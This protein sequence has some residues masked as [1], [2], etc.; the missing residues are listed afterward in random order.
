VD[1][2]AVELVEERDAATEQDRHQVDPQLVEQTQ[3]QAPHGVEW[4]RRATYPSSDIDIS[5]TTFVPAPLIAP[6]PP[7]TGQV[8][9]AV[10]SRPVPGPGWLHPLPCPAVA[11]DTGLRRAGQTSAGGPAMRDGSDARTVAGV[12]TPAR[13]LVRHLAVALAITAAA[14]ACSDPSDGGEATTSPPVPETSAPTSTPPSS[15]PATLDPR[16]PRLPVGSPTDVTTGLAAP[17]SVAFVG[18]APLVSERDSGRILE[19][20]PDGSTRQVGVVD[21]IVHRAE[22]GLLGLAVDGEQRLYA[23]S[24]A[25]DGNRVQR[26]ALTGSR[27]T[28]ALGAAE[29]IIDGI[30]ANATHDGG[31][32]AFGP[33]GMLYVT[34]G[35]AQDRPAAQDLD[36]PSGKILRM[37]PDGGVPP[38]NP[39]AGSLVYSYGHRNVQGIGWAADGTMFASEFG[40]NT[41]DELNLIEAGGNYGWPDVEGIAGADGRIDPVQQWATADASPSGLAVAGGTVYLANLRGEVLRS[42]PVADPEATATEHYADQYGRLRAVTVAPDGSLWIITNNTDGRGSPTTGDDRILRVELS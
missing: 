3:P 13:R 33:D 36:S 37:T 29:T 32:L 8:A 6:H 4:S 42:V 19:V 21:G 40:Q 18:D 17:W 41:W 26:F 12:A 22:D 24:T 9:I 31:R 27:G 20:L 10:A 34:V 2:R 39:F 28:Y 23:Y 1:R 11:P 7:L 16:R 5:I 38:D 35:D 15:T 25:N 14:A 30:P